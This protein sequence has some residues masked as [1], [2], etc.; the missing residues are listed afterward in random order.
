M[1]MGSTLA[2]DLLLHQ[3]CR[4]MARAASS[5]DDFAAP[6]YASRIELSLLALAAFR[7]TSIHA[8]QWSLCAVFR[9]CASGLAV[10]PFEW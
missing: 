8:Q 6:L 1:R 2:E 10:A 9:R 4:T 7:L 5:R 3:D